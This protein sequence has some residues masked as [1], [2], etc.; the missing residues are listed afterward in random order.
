M[1]DETHLQHQ[2]LKQLRVQKK[3]ATVEK[4]ETKEYL[5]LQEEYVCIFNYVTILRR[6]IYL[7][8]FIWL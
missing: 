8:I 4:A 1:E 3:N 5:Q 7:Y 2:M 6:I